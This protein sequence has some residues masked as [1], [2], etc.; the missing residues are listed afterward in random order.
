MPTIVQAPE[1][2]ATKS[3]SGPLGLPAK[4][5]KELPAAHAAALRDFDHLP[6]S[7]EVPVRVVAARFSVHPM[8]VWKWVKAGK[9]PQP[10]RRGPQTVRWNVGL[11]RQHLGQ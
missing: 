3:R 2:A 6:D 5:V 4:S 11:L 7:A 9:L 10:V 1:G 8:T